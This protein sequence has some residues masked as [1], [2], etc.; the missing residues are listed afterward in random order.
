MHP[1]LSFITPEPKP[2][3]MHQSQIQVCSGGVPGIQVSGD[4]NSIAAALEPRAEFFDPEGASSAGTWFP[5]MC[6]KFKNLTPRLTPAGNFLKSSF[7]NAAHSL[8]GPSLKPRFSMGWE[9]S[10]LHFQTPVLALGNGRVF[11]E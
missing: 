3:F 6:E 7:L 1:D 11:N 8:K 9:G 10:R 5:P 2:D 4:K